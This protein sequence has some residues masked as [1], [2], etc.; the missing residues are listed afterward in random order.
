MADRPIL[1]SSP[2]VRALLDGHKTQTRRVLRIPRGFTVE[3]LAESNPGHYSGL[4]GDASSWGDNFADDGGPMSLWELASLSFAAG[5]RLW[6]RETWSHTGDGVFEIHQAR[7]APTG[8][9]IYAA[10]PAPDAPH[11]KYWPS[12]HMPREF[13]RLTL[14]VSDTRVERLQDISE[15]DAIA[16]GATCRPECS[17]CMGRYPGWSM[18]WSAV[19]KQSRFA[20]NDGVLSERD[21]SHGT[22]IAAF[23]GFINELHDPRWNL[24]GDGIFGQNPWVVA[25]T[26][27]VAKA[28]IDALPKSE[29]A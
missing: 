28:N 21:I 4:P 10:T 2:M 16:E 18:D 22:P 26:F 7:I 15:A 3:N 1:F 5:D 25:L 20:R 8:R 6:V 24:K 13:S 23:A 27:T 17:G 11:A 12:I 19:G 9:V 14:T 29:A